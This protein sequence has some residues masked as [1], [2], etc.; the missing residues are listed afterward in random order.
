WVQGTLTMTT[1]ALGTVLHHLRRSLL[2]QDEAHLTDGELLG[3]FLSRRDESAFEALLRRHGP[4]VLGVCRRVLRN[5]AD[6]EDAFQAT[7]LVLVR[8]AA[9]IR[10]RGMVGNWLYGVAHT[11]ALKARA[12]NTRR[13]TREREAALPPKPEATAETQR[14][15]HAL[16]DQELKVLPD[17]YRAAI[18]LCDLEGKTR[19]DA[20]RH[21]GVPDG[22]LAARLARG[23][24]MLAKRLTRRGLAVSGASLEVVM[25]QFAASASVP[26]SVVSSTINAA[27]V[28][29]AGQAASGAISPAVAILTEGVLK[30]ML[31]SKLKIATAVLVA[32]VLLVAGI[33]LPGLLLAAGPTQPPK[34][35]KTGTPEGETPKG[36]R[37]ALPGKEDNQI[38]PVAGGAGGTEM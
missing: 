2:R 31:L 3:C 14:Q 33:S 27:T 38:R 22:T 34:T 12:M 15:L 13:L 24:V 10:P 25:A 7:F 23:R 21:L 6:A 30:S 4:M 36:E 29:A 28:F 11:T 18:V 19:Q 16:L 32:A 1:T 20:A 17:K 37:K 8:K 35:E 26:P 5:E 9:T